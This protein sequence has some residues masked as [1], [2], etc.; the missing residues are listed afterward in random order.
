MILRGH[1]A[2]SEFRMTALLERLRSGEDGEQVSVCE[3]REHYLERRRDPEGR[4]IILVENFPF[5]S[6]EFLRQMGEVIHGLDESRLGIAIGK[7]QDRIQRHDAKLASEA[8]E[9]DEIGHEVNP[10][11][12]SLLNGTFARHDSTILREPDEPYSK[13]G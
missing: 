7:A 6:S 10:S 9:T 8:E 13:A 3:L 4:P 11:S 1:A 5:D 2:L 12:V